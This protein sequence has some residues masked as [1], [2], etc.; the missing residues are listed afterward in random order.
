MCK[1]KLC[2]KGSSSMGVQN[3]VHI[4]I[5]CAITPFAICHLRCTIC[6]LDN[7]SE[8][9]RKTLFHKLTLLFCSLLFSYCGQ[10]NSYALLHFMQILLT[11]SL[12]LCLKYKM[13]KNGGPQEV[14]LKTE[15]I[16]NTSYVGFKW[17]CSHC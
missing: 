17:L 9:D 11:D 2:T 6:H 8:I 7:H 12:P 14:S 10:K 13:Y 16:T 15:I 1:L 5:C 3:T 4:T